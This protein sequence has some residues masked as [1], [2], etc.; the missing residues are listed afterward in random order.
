MLSRQMGGDG[1]GGVAVQAV[2]GV[3]VPAGSARGL[4]GRRSPA[5]R[6]GRRPQRGRGGGRLRLRHQD[7]PVRLPGRR[8][9]TPGACSGHARA[10]RPGPIRRPRSSPG[11]SFT[12]SWGEF[13]LVHGHSSCRPIAATSGGPAEPGATRSCSRSGVSPTS[14][15]GPARGRAVS[16]RRSRCSRQA[17]HPGTGETAVTLHARAARAPHRTRR[18]GNS[19]P[20]DGGDER[21][22]RGALARRRPTS[23]L[24]ALRRPAASEVAC[25][26][27]ASR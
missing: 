14:S 22:H 7:H 3:V 15:S 12:S 5:R 18:A 16:R 6:A 21:A 26:I 27:L 25:G 8:G 24:T 4:C 11:R 1:A 17:G 19:M 13:R 2:A 9:R 23:S 10:P 20:G